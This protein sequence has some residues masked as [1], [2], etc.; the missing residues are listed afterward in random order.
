MLCRVVYINASWEFSY[1]I[2]PNVDVCFVHMPT[3]N[4]AYYNEQL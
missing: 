1:Q 4:I 3:D 2:E